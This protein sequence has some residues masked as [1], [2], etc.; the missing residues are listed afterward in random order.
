MRV[1][2]GSDIDTYA[3]TM[4]QV[5]RFRHRHFVDRFGWEDVRRADGREIDQFDTLAAIH[6][7]L[8]SDGK[9]VAYS[10]L[11]PTDQ[12]HLLSD[13]YPQIMGGRTWPRGTRIYEWTRCVAVEEDVQVKSVRASNLMMS[14]VV[15][16]CL[17]AGVEALIAQTSPKLVHLLLFTGWHVEPLNGPQQYNDHTLV[18][19]KATPSIKTLEKHRRIYKFQSDILNLSVPTANPLKPTEFL[20]PIWAQGLNEKIAVS[21]H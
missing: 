4:E 14:G 3:E 16:F 13:V 18:P 6:L 17:V 5:W 2:S 20:Q 7:P 11:L 9:V 10:R 1:I 12:P 21:A 19:I 8:M 15:E